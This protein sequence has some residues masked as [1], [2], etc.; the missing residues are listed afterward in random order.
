[1]PVLVQNEKEPLQSQMYLGST[2]KRGHFDQ[3]SLI[4]LFTP[5]YFAVAASRCAFKQ[6]RTFIFSQP[7]KS[8][9]FGIKANKK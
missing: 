5:T 9:D 8:Y 1:M 7:L 2:V 3:I 6:T 4:S